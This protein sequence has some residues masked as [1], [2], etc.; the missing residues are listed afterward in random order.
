[1]T[2]LTRVIIHVKARLS[3]LTATVFS[4]WFPVE[5][6]SFEAAFFQG[7][8]DTLA[9]CDASNSHLKAF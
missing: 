1:M 5:T 7:V 2:R 9:V 8:E 4:W 6:T 3:I